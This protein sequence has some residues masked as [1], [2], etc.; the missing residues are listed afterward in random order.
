MI[1]FPTVVVDD[2]WPNPDEVVNLAYSDKITWSPSGGPW[3]GLRSQAVHE[4]DE[5]FFAWTQK[6]YFT[7]FWPNSELMNM[8][9]TFKASSFF[10]RIPAGGG[11]W[12]HSDF[13][14]VHTVIHYLSK[15]ADGRSGTGIYRPKS[16]ETS[17]KHSDVK[18]KVYNGEITVEEGEKYRCA[19]NDGFVE[20]MFV[21]NKFN[22]CIGFDSS[23]WHGVRDFDTATGEDRLTM[24][25]FFHSIVA[26]GFPMNRFRSVAQKVH[27]E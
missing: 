7:L 17:A 13:P 15:D 25:T 16:L 10:Q 1:T 5:G 18:R 2:F 3:P 6:K 23:L 26:N 8:G 4:V 11:G 19:N 20:E 12:I 9:M 24:V 22:R 14:D 21:A 27:M